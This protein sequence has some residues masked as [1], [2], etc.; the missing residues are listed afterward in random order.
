M[1]RVG[2]LSDVH[3]PY[4]DT[5]AWKLTLKILPELNLDSIGIAG[6]FVD[7]EP[8][9]RFVVHPRRRLELRPQ[10]EI[11]RRE[12]LLPLRSVLPH[13][14]IWHMAGNHCQRMEKYLY[15]KAPELVDIDAL[16]VPE[17]LGLKKSDLD[18]KPIA[19]GVG[20]NLGKLH[21][22]HGDEIKV[23]AATPA[24]A[25]LAK[26]NANILVGHHHK[27]D[28]Y[29]QNSYRGEVKGA[30]VNGCLC[31]LDPD[32]HIFP[33]WQQGFSLIDVT[34]SGFFHVEQVLIMR[35]K[36]QLCAMVGDKFFSV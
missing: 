29:L 7:F 20:T 17:L 26:V 23:G 33:N 32:W 6:D 30:W 3:F 25:L 8:V 2:I 11:A 5:K 9:S 24:K 14:Q 34:S 18:I 12:G 10:V 35:R 4:H 15:N 36:G 21:I 31:R 27:F 1:T 22:L 13:G 16:T 19:W 28:R